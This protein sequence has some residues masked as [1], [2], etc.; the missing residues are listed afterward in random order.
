MA[1][2]NQFSPT[3]KQDSTLLMWYQESG[4]PYD[5]DEALQE[6]LGF[7]G[8]VFQEFKDAME[9][10]K[11]LEEY[12]KLWLANVQNDFKDYIARQF[13]CNFD[14]WYADWREKNKAIIVYSRG[15]GATLGVFTSEN[16]IPDAMKQDI[17]AELLH[18]QTFVL[19]ILE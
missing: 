2:K 5:C 4:S 12:V 1:I 13:D 16:N 7:N 15:T 17:K 18:Y 19:N 10:I 8:D 11:E 14:D 3:D 9:G 6:N